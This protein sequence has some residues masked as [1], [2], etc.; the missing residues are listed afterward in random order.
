MEIQLLVRVRSMPQLAVAS[1][2]Q[3]LVVAHARRHVRGVVVWTSGICE[4]PAGVQ[5]EVF[6]RDSHM[7]HPDGSSTGGGH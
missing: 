7:M 2:R 6:V 5:Y 4:R 3:S 1:Q